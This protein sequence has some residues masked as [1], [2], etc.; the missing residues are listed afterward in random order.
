MRRGRTSRAWTHWSNSCKPKVFRVPW[1]P[2][3]GNASACMQPVSRSLQT[4]KKPYSA[5]P[6]ATTLHSAE[7]S[8][9]PGVNA[10]ETALLLFAMPLERRE[11]STGCMAAARLESFPYFRLYSAWQPSLVPSFLGVDAA[12]TII[13]LQPLITISPRRTTG[14]SLLLNHRPRSRRSSR[15]L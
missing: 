10:Q 2:S 7:G 1:L 5:R 9:R 11:R 12:S 3:M 4:Q 13:R 14:R 6:S 8:F 15:L